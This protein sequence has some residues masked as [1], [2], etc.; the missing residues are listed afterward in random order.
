MPTFDYE[1]VGCKTIREEHHKGSETPPFFC[2]K[3]GK[4]MKKV[5][6]TAPLMKMGYG[7]AWNGAQGE[8]DKMK[9]KKRKQI[10]PKIEK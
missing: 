9:K 10:V 3:C 8:I 5:F 7:Q 6:L 1:C 4:S 2:F